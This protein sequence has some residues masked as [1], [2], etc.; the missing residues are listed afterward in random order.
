VGQPHRQ[1]A[2]EHSIP[3][4]PEHQQDLGFLGQPDEGGG[5][6]HVEGRVLLHAQPEGA[7]AAGWQGTIT[8][9]QDT[10]NP[11]DTSYGYSNAAL[12]V[13]SQFNQNSKYI[14]GNFVY[15]NLEGYIQDNWKV[16]NR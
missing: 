3:G 7:T 16:N 11:L 15:T 8:F 14:E 2:T 1:R 9:G 10:S 4:L 5:P 12:G 13:F 6:P